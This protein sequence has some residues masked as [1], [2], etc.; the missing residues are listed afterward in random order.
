ML[1]QNE[2]LTEASK[3]NKTAKEKAAILD[4]MQN[5]M[6]L[7]EAATIARQEAFNEVETKLAEKIARNNEEK[8]FIRYSQNLG[9]LF[10]Y[11]TKNNMK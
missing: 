3:N 8:E 5:D 1:Y 7:N 6:R 4:K 2:T 11:F 10:D 9:G